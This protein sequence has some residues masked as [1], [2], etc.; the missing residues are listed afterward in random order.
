MKKYKKILIIF[1]S[2]ILLYNLAWVGVFYL[3]YTPYTENIPKRENG[4]YLLSERGYHYSVKKPS[5]LSFTGN[6]AITNDEDDLSL[7]IWPLLTGGYEYGLQI[8]GENNNFYSVMVDSDMNY[9][10]DENSESMDK[11]LVNSLINKRAVEIEALKSEVN[12]IWGIN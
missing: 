10:D 7:I 1:V 9:L 3:K 8:L 12:R 6:L 5:Y 2:L 4:I 11:D